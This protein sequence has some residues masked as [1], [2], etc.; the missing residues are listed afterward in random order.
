ML[1]GLSI[2]DP[3]F[4]RP[5][6]EVDAWNLR[7]AVQ[8]NVVDDSLAQDLTGR[9]TRRPLPDS[10]PSAFALLFPFRTGRQLCPPHF[11]RSAASVDGL[12]RFYALYLAW[13]AAPPRVWCPE[14]EGLLFNHFADFAL[15]DPLFPDRTGAQARGTIPIP[16]S[17]HR[18][19]RRASSPVRC[20]CAFFLCDGKGRIPCHRR[21]DEPRKAEDQCARPGARGQIPDGA[22]A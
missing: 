7:A 1:R 11:V 14:R 20:R 9:E 18:C 17:E 15:A 2:N 5:T 22:E 3:S 19:I 12:L 16:F 13:L 8:R 10:E 6:H 4:P 21:P